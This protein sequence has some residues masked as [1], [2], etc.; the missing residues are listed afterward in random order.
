MHHRVSWWRRRGGGGGG[1]PVG[2]VAGIL[3]KELKPGV[4][5]LLENNKWHS[6]ILHSSPAKEQI[7]D[8]KFML[9]SKR[10]T[11]LLHRPIKDSSSTP[12][13]QKTRHPS[14][15]YFM[16]AVVLMLCPP[17]GHLWYG[18]VT[19]AALAPGP[20]E[21]SDVYQLACLCPFAAETLT[22]LLHEERCH[23]QACL[24]LIMA[25]T[26]IPVRLI[27]VPN[28]MFSHHLVWLGRKTNGLV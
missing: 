10:L 2:E 16:S 6:F 18:G 15:L 5:G 9:T 4:A 22:S 26:F 20:W 3:K 23:T 21:R 24:F 8:V 7:S 14:V 11:N 19:G 12:P 13:T 28:G 27:W 17:D 25:V 1:E